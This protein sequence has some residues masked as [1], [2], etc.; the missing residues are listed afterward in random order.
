[1]AGRRRGAGAA[2]VRG[3]MNVGTPGYRAVVSVRNGMFNQGLRKSTPLGKPTLSVGNITTGGT[4]KTPM[5][6]Y[7]ANQLIEKGLRPAVL[8]RGYKATSEH[9]SDEM[10]LVQSQLGERGVV[11][12]DPSRIQGAQAVLA[13]HRPLVDVFLLDDGFQHRQAKRDLDLVLIDA[14]QPFGFGRLLPRGLLRE[15]LANLQRADAIILTRVDQVTTTQKQQLDETIQKITGQRPIAYVS[16]PWVG[17]LDAKGQE[18]SLSIL[19]ERPVLGACGIGNPQAFEAS[20]CE[21]ASKVV[22]CVVKPD[23]HVWTR[24]DIDD[25]LDQAKAAGN[26]HVVITEK[27][28]TKFPPPEISPGSLSLGEFQASVGSVSIFR[29]QQGIHFERG[30]GALAQLIEDRIM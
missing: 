9:G 15:P 26:A 13:E 28:F 7:L 5:V 24:S 6:C 14:V 18:H 2:V 3:L 27:D 29:A 17:L 21:H 1:M 30:E 12:A 4:G 10:N 25:L 20:L 8:M 23:H 19:R 22:G 11:H 16:Y